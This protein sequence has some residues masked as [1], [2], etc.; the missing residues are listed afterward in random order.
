MGVAMISYDKDPGNNPRFTEMLR[1]R[2]N[3]REIDL[4][5]RLGQAPDGHVY[6]D[7]ERANLTRMF[8]VF[9]DKMKTLAAECG[10]DLFD[11]LSKMWTSEW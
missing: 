7:Q 3:M 11:P 4:N 6:M 5:L 10:A 1:M 8:Y 9:Q 2:D